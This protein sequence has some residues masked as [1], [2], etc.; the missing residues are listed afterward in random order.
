MSG[1]LEFS[2]NTNKI[3]EYALDKEVM[4]IGR[5]DDNDIRIDNPGSLHKTD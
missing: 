3:G 5:K 1:K 2:F 4:T